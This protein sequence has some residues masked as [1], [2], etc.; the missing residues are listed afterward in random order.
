MEDVKQLE[1]SFS[2]PNG[3]SESEIDRYATKT[4]SLFLLKSLS[5]NE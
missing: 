3:A 5:K 2:L 1:N 4:G